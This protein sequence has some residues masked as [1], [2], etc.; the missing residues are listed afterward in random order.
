LCLTAAPGGRAQSACATLESAFNTALSGGDLQAIAASARQVLEDNT[1]PATVRRQIERKAALAHVREAGR[2]PRSTSANAD[3]LKILEAGV[4]FGRPWQL[5]AS[6][7]DA[8]AEAKDYGGASLAYQSALTD[9][10]DRQS[11]P[12]P[13]AQSEIERLR[14]LAEQNRMLASD[15]VPGDILMTRDVRGFVIQ[16][17]ALPVQ[18][19]FG[20][21]EMTAVGR[22][23]A[24]EMVKLLADQG[25]P[26]ILLVGHTDP[27]GGDAPNL[28]LSLRRAQSVKK[29][30]VE[31]GYDAKSIEVDGR[32]FHEPFAVVNKEDY[33]QEQ[34]YQ[35]YRRVEVKFR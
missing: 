14:H 31:R 19:V 4:G 15:F 5:M 8:R 1:C 32:G 18:F 17:T 25:R 34:I 12:T 20:R 35:M 3:R 13:P 27:I 28:E 21:D 22:Q 29:Y 23:Y 7:G 10:N 30:L 24:D 33:S 6:I 9:I 11:V 26:L 2:L 16:A